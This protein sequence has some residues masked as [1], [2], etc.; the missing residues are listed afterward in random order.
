MTLDGTNT[1][2]IDGRVAVDPGP[3]DE[4]HLRAIGPVEIVLR[5]HNHID[6]VEGI[7]R[8]VEMTGAQEHPVEKAD[9]AGLTAIPSPGH[10]RD[11]VSY[12]LDRGGDRVILTGDT[13]L[14]RGSS[15]VMWP[16]GDVGAYLSTLR[17]LAGLA[18]VPVLPGHGP[19]LPDCATA[20]AW[21]LE[22]R[23]ER[24]E[25]VKGALDRGAETAEDV[26][27]MVYADTPLS[28]RVA[29]EWSVRAQ[30]EYLRGSP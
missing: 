4:G 17:T 22:H 14:G 11:S 20:A 29:A 9:V 1:W 10:T 25:Q 5:T 13:I 24:L 16:D 27:E 2:I 8:L 21:L 6:H 23:L 19:A 15:V 12:L 30:L 18:G 26:V 3:L 7:P 28:L